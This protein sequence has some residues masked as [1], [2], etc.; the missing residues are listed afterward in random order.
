ME[1][2]PV[3]EKIKQKYIN[4]KYIKENGPQT[5]EMDENKGFNCQ[6]FAHLALE[7]I[8]GFK[9]PPVVLSKEIYEKTGDVFIEIEPSVQGLME[10]DIVLFGPNNN[11]DTDPRTLHLGIVTNRGKD[12]GVFHFHG[13]GNEKGFRE[14]QLSAFSDI[15]N[16]EDFRHCW[17]VRRLNPEGLLNFNPQDF[18]TVEEIQ[19]FYQKP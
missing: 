9:L 13:N 16:R 18:P 2:L 19:I 4:V 12:P 17:G 3:I 11:P 10:G 5:Y 6:M 14:N 8:T 15:N 7:A 1:R